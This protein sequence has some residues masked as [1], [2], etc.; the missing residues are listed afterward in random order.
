[1]ERPR[2]KRGIALASQAVG[3]IQLEWDAI[4]Q[5]TWEEL[6][7]RAGRSSIEQS[8]AYGAAV[9]DTANR[10]VRR[11]VVIDHQGP[12]AIV[13]AFE[14][15]LAGLGRS[16]QILRGPVWLGDSGDAERQLD[17]FALIRSTWRR[18]RRELLVWM[19]EIAG[20]PGSEALMR[21]LGARRMVTGY[22]SAWIDMTRTDE[23]LRAGLH[24]KWRNKLRGAE[25][26][27]LRT[28]M[29]S[30]DGPRLD[31]LLDRYETHRRKIRYLGPAP[32]LIRAFAAAVGKKREVLVMRALHDG[33]PIA[34]ILLLCHGASATY[35]VGWT[36]DEGRRRRAHNLLLW[37]GA[38]ALRERGITWLD[39]GGINPAAPGVARFKL[40]MGG[41][42]VTLAGTYI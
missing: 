3:D 17:A 16:I 26:A 27:G 8:W 34:G 36:S 30:G 2:Q 25:A 20:C 14:R 40:G 39:L 23:A 29:A 38:L 15:R 7:T 13:Q 28:D 22:S 4:Q 5:T 42:F 31:W 6:L 37:R 32:A 10:Q 12:I 21:M 24:P 1:M 41:E 19:P 35:F 33:A 11:G 18:S 9:A